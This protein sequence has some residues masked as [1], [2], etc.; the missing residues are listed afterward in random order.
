MNFDINRLIFFKF[1]AYVSNQAPT[2][3]I[4]VHKVKAIFIEHDI[5]DKLFFASI[6]DETNLLFQFLLHLFGVRPGF[7]R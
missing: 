2:M 3:D 5:A 1:F 6:L 4:P 7:H